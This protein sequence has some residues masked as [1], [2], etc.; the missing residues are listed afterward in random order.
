MSASVCLSVCLS[1]SIFRELHAQLSSNF[2]YML[3]MTVA[4]FFSV[5]VAILYALP[6]LW[7]ALIYT[8]WSELRNSRCAEGQYSKRLNR[9]QHEFDTVAYTQT[10]P[11]GGSTGRRRSLISTIVFFYDEYTHTRLTALCPGLYPSEPV[12]ERYKKLSYRRVTARCVVSVEI[13]PI[14][15]QQCRNYL[16][17]KS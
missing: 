13:L 9:R 12:P 17:D 1:A 5:G 16:H 4:R 11:P 10:G 8:Y 3:P 14:T 7:I 6:I 15:T 2:L